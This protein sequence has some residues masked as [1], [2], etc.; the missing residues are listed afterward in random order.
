MKTHYDPEVDALYIR[1]AEVEIVEREE[2][3]DGVTF[4]FDNEGR[5]VSLEILHASKH[6]APGATFST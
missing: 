4:D 6:I 5:I 1:F 2:V 3:F